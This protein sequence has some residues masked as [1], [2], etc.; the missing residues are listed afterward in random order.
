MKVFS[1]NQTVCPYCYGKINLNK[2]A[3][4]CSGRG[5]PGKPVCGLST[6]TVR[7]SYFDDNKPYRPVLMSGNTK[8]LGKSQLKCPHCLGDTSQRICPGC[9]SILPVSLDKDSNLIGLVGARR[10]GKTVLLSVLHRELTK[11]IGRRFNASIDNPGGGTGLAGSLAI[12]EREM[13]GASRQLP[14][15][16]DKSG[17]R[18]LEPAVYEW[19]YMRGNA[20]AGTIFS[21]YDTAGED[22]ATRESA[23]DERYLGAAAGTILLLDPFSFSEN[24]SKALAKGAATSSSEADRNTSPEN[25][26]DSI[27]YA[28]QTAHN[29]KPGKRIKQPLAVAITKIDAFLDDLPQGH[30]LRQAAEDVPRFDNSQSQTIHDHMAALIAQWGG[31]HLLRKLDQNFENYRLFGISALGAEPNYRE[32]TANARG[33]SPLRVAEPFLWLMAEWNFIPTRK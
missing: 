5:V 18:N 21:F 12:W 15:Q 13:S 8:L 20:S 3:F 25:V 32:S 10:S 14:A 27:T 7:Q 30:P 24:R 26:L 1:K 9:H 22:V 29:V 6:D 17:G 23:S 31:E 4:R 2:V 11:K 28:L 33:V 16:T 19:R